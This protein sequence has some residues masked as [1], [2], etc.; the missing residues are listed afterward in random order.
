MNHKMTSEDVRAYID[1]WSLVN[2]EERDELRRTPPKVKFQQLAA[3][4]ASV[5]QM[6]W[7]GKLAADEQEVWQR[8]QAIRRA[9]GVGS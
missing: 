1:R 7:E 9:Y 8:W 3:L 6:G 4:M 2:E 5:K